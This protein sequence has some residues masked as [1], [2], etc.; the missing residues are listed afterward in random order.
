M[1][2]AKVCNSLVT[3]LDTSCNK[4]VDFNAFKLK[5]RESEREKGGNYSLLLLREEN[6]SEL[7]FI[8]R[9]PFQFDVFGYTAMHTMCGFVEKNENCFRY[10]FDTIPYPISIPGEGKEGNC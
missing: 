6:I 2:C 5:A 10:D 4:R 8:L 9:C 1:A 7:P 3:Y